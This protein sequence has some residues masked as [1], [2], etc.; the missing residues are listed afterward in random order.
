MQ[1]AE[2]G[3]SSVAAG[4]TGDDDM[5]THKESSCAAIEAAN[6]ISTEASFGIEE[7]E[8]EEL[9]KKW[10]TWCVHTHM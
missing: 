2:A 1:A 9:E 8:A 6:T 10:I 5:L 7:G 4:A 3:E